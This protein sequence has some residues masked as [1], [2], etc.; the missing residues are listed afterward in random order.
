MPGP[1]AAC[2]SATLR[3][4]PEFCGKNTPLSICASSTILVPVC[5]LA[6]TSRECGF[7]LRRHRNPINHSPSINT[8]LAYFVAILTLCITHLRLYPALWFTSIYEIVWFTDVDEGDKRGSAPQIPP[9][10]TSG[11]T[12]LSIISRRHSTASLPR[13]T[14]NQPPADSDPQRPPPS[15][16]PS[17]VW[18]GRLLP[19]QPGK[20]HPFRFRRAR[21]QEFQWWT[22]DNDQAASD[23]ARRQDPESQAQLSVSKPQRPPRPSETLDEDEPVPLGD[24]SQWVRA[25]QVPRSHIPL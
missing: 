20:D 1:T 17:N 10:D 13:Y 25:G 11:A 22:G 9:L 12:R 6:A 21:G 16:A 24:R 2:I 8:V 14:E 15:P 3:G 5:W 23:N 18:W 7:L 4:P 19:G